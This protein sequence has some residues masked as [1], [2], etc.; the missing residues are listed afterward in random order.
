MR[1][2]T[3]FSSEV[4]E[5]GNKQVLFQAEYFVPIIQQANI[6][7]LLFYAGRVYSEEE[8][9]EFDDFVSDVGF[10]SMDYTSC[11]I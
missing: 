9:V 1:G 6:R 10:V 7:A 11:A 3:G 5:G 4:V 2:A 8:A